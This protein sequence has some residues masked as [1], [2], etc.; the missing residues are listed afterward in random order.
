M[1]THARE[2]TFKRQ[3]GASSLF[4]TAILVLLIMMLGVTTAVISN[5][6]FK[7]AG[8]TQFESLAFNLAEG[9]LATGER[10][11]TTGANAANAGFKTRSTGTPQLYPT[12]LTGDNLDPVTMTWD[13]TNSVA[14]NGDGS[15]RYL[16]E[17]IG[18]DKI[19]LGND[20]GIGAP[21]LGCK[22][23]DVFRIA[24]RG[25]SARGTTKLVQTM[26]AIPSC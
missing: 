18:K 14:V 11:L 21:G 26:Y 13:D 16:I 9:A 24:A 10:W 23:F 2:F 20:E 8:N 12:Y 17:Q 22:K 6:Q 4:V 19:I 25:T 1:K 7:L 5:T 3:R 15:Q